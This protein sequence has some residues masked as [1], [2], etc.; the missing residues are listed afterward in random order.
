MNN[1]FIVRYFV[2]SICLLL[3][4]CAATVPVETDWSCLEPDCEN[5]VNNGAKKNNDTVSAEMPDSRNIEYLIGPGD[6]LQIFVWRNP[7][8]STTI[9]VRP[10]GRISLPLIDD[11][12]AA[13]KTPLA[14]AGQIKIRLARYIRE[15]NVSVMVIEFGGAYNQQVKV[16]GEVANA[17]AIPYRKNMTALDAM[18]V[19]GG[20]TEYAAGNRATIIRKHEFGTDTIPLR[21]ND[22]LKKGKVKKNISLLPGDIL[23]VPEARF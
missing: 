18:I 17:Q 9:P 23:L 12:V 19:V 21:L 3:S 10:D 5:I 14:L 8:L 6:K 1:E 16:V 2:A 22:L 7:E 15:P 4:A 13:D 20:L 11:I